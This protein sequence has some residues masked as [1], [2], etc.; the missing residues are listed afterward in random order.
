MMILM[1]LRKYK[2]ENSADWAKVLG[3]KDFDVIEEG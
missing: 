3:G 2:D 1:N